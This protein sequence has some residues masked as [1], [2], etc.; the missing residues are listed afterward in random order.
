VQVQAKKRRLALGLLAGAGLVILLVSLYIAIPWLRTRFS[1]LLRLREW[2]SNPSAHPDWVIQAG[3][4]CGDAPFVMPTD[5]Y[6]GFLWGD[7]F[8]PGQRHQGLDI[9]GGQAVGLTPVVATYPGYLTRLETWK[10]AVILRIPHDPLHPAHQIWLYYAH[11]AD[12]AGNT[13]IDPQFP[14]G[15]QE[16]YVEAGTRL[17]YQGD[18]SGDPGNPTGIHLHF[19]IVLD[20]G[21]GHFRNELEIHNTLDPS[22]YLGLPLN[23]AANYGQLAVCPAGQVLVGHAVSLPHLII[24]QAVSLSYKAQP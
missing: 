17:G 1:R 9:F 21:Q 24:G 8:R 11:M 6:I 2:F 15:T 20:D 23:A 18:Y 22:P 12:S 19:S 4:R 16:V 7:S 14:A 10:S 3:T 5:G 13:F